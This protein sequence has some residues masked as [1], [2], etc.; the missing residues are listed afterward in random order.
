M[1]PISGTEKG[2]VGRDLKGSSNILG[3]PG[4][5]QAVNPRGADLGSKLRKMALAA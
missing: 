2:Y 3:D 5:R 4:L 1:P